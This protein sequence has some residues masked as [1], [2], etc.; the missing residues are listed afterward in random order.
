MAAPTLEDVPI[1]VGLGSTIV[2]LTLA[3]GESRWQVSHIRE[4]KRTSD[5]K[6]EALE[7]RI[8]ALE[9][10]EGRTLERLD[11]FSDRLSRIEEKLDRLLERHAA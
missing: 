11:S 1:L 8:A 2:G 3:L 5:A 6:I 10:R 7:G 9:V 4:G